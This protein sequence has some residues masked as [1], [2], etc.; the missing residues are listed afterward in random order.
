MRDRSDQINAYAAAH[1]ALASAD[2]VTAKI[3]EGA[4][5]ATRVTL[6]ARRSAL[7]VRT[8]VIRQIKSLLVTPGPS[9]L[10]T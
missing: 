9:A 5:E 6:A 3:I 2:T 7:K 1:A 4:V 10:G 8:E